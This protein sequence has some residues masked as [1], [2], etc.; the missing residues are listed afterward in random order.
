MIET[1]NGLFDADQIPA[2]AALLGWLR[3][4][5]LNPEDL[6][7]DQTIEVDDDAG[8]IRYDALVRDKR[9]EVV[10]DADDRGPLRERRVLQLDAPAAPLPDVASGWWSA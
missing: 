7:V 2:H 3:A 6:P 4:H 9:G 5:G 1:H 10:R 8:Q